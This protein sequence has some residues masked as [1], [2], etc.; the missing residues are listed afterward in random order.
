MSASLRTIPGKTG[1]A[2]CLDFDFN[3]VTGAASISEDGAVEVSHG[4]F[5][6]EPFLIDGGKLVTWAD[7]KTSQSLR[8]RYLPIPS[9]RWEAGKLALTTTAFA[10]GDPGRSQLVV[11]YRVAN[12]GD[13]ARD[14]TLALAARPFQV[15]PPTQFLNAPG[16]TSHVDDLAW[17]G[18]ASLPSGETK[19]APG[20]TGLRAHL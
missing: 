3:G 10:Q 15:N 12:D 16:G 18:H 8:D 17:D 4:S 9:V 2:P 1:Q 20:Q 19:L 7:V 13:A 5:S 11:S 14:V 6:I